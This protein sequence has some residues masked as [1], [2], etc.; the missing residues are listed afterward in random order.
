M[1][2]LK[3]PLYS[4]EEAY[5]TYHAHY[6]C[7]G[8]EIDKF[9]KWL[10][11]QDRNCIGGTDCVEIDHIVRDQFSEINDLL[12]LIVLMFG[13]YGTSPNYGWIER[14]DDCLDWLKNV[15]RY[16]EDCYD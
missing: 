14:V 12:P 2:E 15:R 10:S 1:G 13:N 8:E 6:C 16:W 11:E 9:A 3:N 5:F 4:F 7:L